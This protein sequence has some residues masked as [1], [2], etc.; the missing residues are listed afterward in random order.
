MDSDDVYKVDAHNFEKLLPDIISAIESATF[1][2]I[3][4]EFTALRNDDEF[5][6][7][8]FDTMEE[9][10]RKLT[11]GLRHVAIHQFGL[12]LFTMTSSAPCNNYK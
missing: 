12:A 8:F 9:R 1:F 4:L 7:S 2:G 6:G 10:Y 3:D 5:R 11:R